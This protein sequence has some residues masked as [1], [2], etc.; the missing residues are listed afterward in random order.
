MKSLIKS[1]LIL[2]SIHLSVASR[3]KEIISVLVVS[4]APTFH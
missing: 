1:Y 2:Y 3:P 4:G